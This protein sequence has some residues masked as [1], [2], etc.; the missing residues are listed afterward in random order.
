MEFEEDDINLE[1]NV[2]TIFARPNINL[3]EIVEDL[4]SRAVAYVIS[5][6]ALYDSFKE[7]PKAFLRNF[8]T[9]LSVWFPRRAPPWATLANISLVRDLDKP[10]QWPDE[11]M[12]EEEDDD[13]I[14]SDFD[15]QDA[16]PTSPDATN[17]TER[18]TAP[19]RFAFWTIIA[20][21]A[22]CFSVVI[23]VGAILIRMLDKWLQPYLCT[24]RK[25]QRDNKP[26]YTVAQETAEG[27][28]N[29]RYRSFQGHA[30]TSGHVAHPLPIPW[31][32]TPCSQRRKTNANGTLR[33]I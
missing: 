6:V 4:W 1:L 20:S 24:F 17:F 29:L 30:E 21:I 2:P 13:D 27:C 3:G 33:H 8:G 5:L 7:S 9:S 26:V 11:L 14:D 10:A 25:K 15:E 18:F 31:P 12:N 32:P 19:V 22:G 23:V 28:D 16:T